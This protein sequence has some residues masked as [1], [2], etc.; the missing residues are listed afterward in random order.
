MCAATVAEL[1]GFDS[2]RDLLARH[3]SE[4]MIQMTLCRPSRDA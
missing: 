3:A 1:G 2:W 4:G